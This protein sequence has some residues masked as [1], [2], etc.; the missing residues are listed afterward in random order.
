[1]AVV[2]SGR[3]S[4]F[5]FRNAVNA[6]VLEFDLRITSDD[7]LVLMHNASVNDT[8]NGVGLVRSMK[9][10]E[11]QKLDAGFK[12]TNDGG[13]TFPFRGKGITVPTLEENV[14]GVQAEAH[15]YRNQGLASD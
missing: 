2:D 10:S 6:D 3:R 7:K 15:E 12:W 13:A 5:A 8:T 1:M 4:L 9:L 11:V 14:A